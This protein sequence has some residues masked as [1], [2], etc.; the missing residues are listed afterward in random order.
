MATRRGQIKRDRPAAWRSQQ[1]AP[2]PAAERRLHGWQIAHTYLITAAALVIVIAGM[3]AAA[4]ILVPFLLAI[5]VAGI[6]APLYQGMRRR[7]VPTPLAIVA[8]MLVM[9][10]GVLL[11]VGVIERAVTGFA[12]NLPQLSGG[13]PRA[14]RQDLALARGERHRRL[15]RAVAGPVQ[16]AGADPL[17]RHDRGHAARPADHDLHRRASSRSSSCSKD[18]R[19]PTRCA[20][21]RACLA[22]PGAI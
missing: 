12:G 6:C 8:I 14:D 7:H 20:G 13:L 10:G 18:R 19:C 17:P 3:R 15:E 4:G 5:F 16:S 21:C 22:R 11:L 9:L 2:P 1:P